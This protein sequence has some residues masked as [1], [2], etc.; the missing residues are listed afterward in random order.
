MNKIVRVCAPLVVLLSVSGPA[1]SPQT[2]GRHSVY[3]AGRLG[4]NLESRDP[5]AGTSAGIGGSFGFFVERW[6]IEME[7]WIPAYITDQACAPPVPAPRS[8]G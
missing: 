2:A 5:G 4:A 8:S 1:V 7:S 3:V 6:A